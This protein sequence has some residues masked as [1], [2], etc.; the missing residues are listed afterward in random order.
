MV[1]LANYTM[2]NFENSYN[3]LKEIVYNESN[4]PKNKPALLKCIDLVKKQFYERQTVRS[5]LK[6]KEFENMVNHV[7]K[8]RKDV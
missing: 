2:K 7:H 8:I 1:C 4:R 5:V 3:R 6:A